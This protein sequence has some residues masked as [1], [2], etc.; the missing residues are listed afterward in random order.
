MLPVARN[1]SVQSRE[2]GFLRHHFL[3]LNNSGMGFYI[4]WQP[5]VLKINRNFGTAASCKWTLWCFKKKLCSLSLLKKKVISRKGWKWTAINLFPSAVHHVAGTSLPY[6][7]AGIAHDWPRSAVSPSSWWRRLF[8]QCFLQL[9]FHFELTVLNCLLDALHVP[10]GSG[11]SVVHR[12]NP[13]ADSPHLCA[14]SRWFQLQTNLVNHLPEVLL[15]LVQAM[16]F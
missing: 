3:L 5:N 12:E 13:V 14:H 11:E 16:D 15:R 8:S 9:C 4:P 7:A 2:Y 6:C 10:L 1:K